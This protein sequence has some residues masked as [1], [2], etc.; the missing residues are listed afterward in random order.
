MDNS[1]AKQKQ[2]T[3]SRREKLH[4]QRCGMYLSYP[5]HKM[6]ECYEEWGK[7]DTVLV[8]SGCLVLI[9]VPPSCRCQVLLCLKDW[10]AS[11][12]NIN[13]SI[14]WCLNVVFFKKYS[15]FFFNIP[16]NFCLSLW[17]VIFVIWKELHFPQMHDF[18]THLF[19]VV[20]CLICI[21][22][23]SWFGEVIH[24]IITS[25]FMQFLLMWSVLV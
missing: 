23:L 3:L 5:L 13:L 21:K 22:L 18:P 17:S 9:T 4:P 14:V 1:G 20:F 10:M 19:T 16:W 24:I 25:L 7:C 2:L 11:L 15:Y 8:I 6:E 12:A